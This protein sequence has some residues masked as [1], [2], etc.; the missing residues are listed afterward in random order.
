MYISYFDEAAY[1][2]L[3]NDVTIN[4]EKYLSDDIWIENYFGGNKYFE[5]SSI[6]VPNISLSHS[7]KLT[8]EQKCQEDI[9]N[10]KMLY[11]A[12]KDYITPLTATN[13][14]MW[15]YLCHRN[16]YEYVVDRWMMNSRDAVATVKT[17]F[18]A[19]GKS[20]K[21]DNAVARLWWYGYITYEQDAPNPFAL[22][23][24][25]L[26]SQQICTDLIDESYSS[27]RTVVKAMLC[28]LKQIKEDH[29]GKG[30]SQPWRDC[31]KYINRFGAVKNLDF[32]GFDAIYNEAY[33]YL[34]SK[35]L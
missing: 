6:F 18:F 9:Q 2:K 22:T 12:Y 5:V 10:V 20:F 23:E 7:T 31:V 27:N 33:H 4:K 21:F 16:F 3:L 19:N 35:V 15:A 11:S 28:A 32:I 13:K 14:Y 25:L 29:P 1:D 30:M 34:R 17:R 24:I 26:S 8:D